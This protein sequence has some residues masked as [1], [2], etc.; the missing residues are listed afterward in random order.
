MV[1]GLFVENYKKAI[2]FKG[3][4]TI[5]AGVIVCKIILYDGIDMVGLAIGQLMSP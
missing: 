2:P 1:G 5:L 4:F 3:D